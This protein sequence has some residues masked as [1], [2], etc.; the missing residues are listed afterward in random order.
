MKSK[1]L[2]ILFWVSLAG[3][4]V[5]LGIPAWRLVNWWIH[6]D[7]PSYSYH[8][9][10]RNPARYYDNRV[11]MPEFQWTI[12]SLNHETLR[13][14][15]VQDSLTELPAY[16]SLAFEQN[17]D[18]LARLDRQR[19]ETVFR[20]CRA[21]MAQLSGAEREKVVRRWRAQMDIA[22]E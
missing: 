14:L 22:G 13:L 10:W 21:A 15:Y 20:S 2:W 5:E 8:N 17:A 3:N 6:A 1:W 9:W 11:M 18:S 19:H 4:A 12:D 7:P 16:D